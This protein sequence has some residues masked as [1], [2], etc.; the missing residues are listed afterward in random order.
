MKEDSYEECGPDLKG[1]QH[2]RGPTDVNECMTTLER[3]QAK[4]IE[5]RCGKAPSDQSGMKPRSSS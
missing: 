1:S 2:G 4:A 5:A 3:E